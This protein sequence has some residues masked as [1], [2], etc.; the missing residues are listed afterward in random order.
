M[1][2]QGV[3]FDTNQGGRLP[4]EKYLAATLIE[5]DALSATGCQTI[6]AAASKHGLN[7]KYFGILWAALT[8]TEPSL[9]LDELRV[10]WR[11]A[12]PEDAAALAADI[13]AWQKSLWNFSS[14]G[15]IGREGGPKRWMEPVNPLTTKQDFSFKIPE[16]PDGADVT[17]SLVA[18]DAGDGN[19]GDFVIWQAPRLVAPG[20][21][22]LLLRDVRRIVCELNT[23]QDQLFATTAAYLNAADE[24]AS[25][26]KVDVAAWP[27]STAWKK[28]TCE[29]GSTTWGL[30]PGCSHRGGILSNKLTGV[31]GFEF[32]NGWGSNDTPLLVANSSDEH[33]RIPGNVKPHSVVVHPSPT[34]RAAVGWRSPIARN[35]RIEG[36]V[37]PAHPECGNGVTWSLD[38]APRHHAAA[39]GRAA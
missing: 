3:V 21:P 11:K 39:T 9:L 23:R 19:E 34:L 16:S 20:R 17:I 27:G 38:R 25:D 6:D 4:V 13:A 7:A 26:E 36:A 18:T 15:L 2:L 29:H 5:R 22:D 33:V 32:V 37:A 1:N 12:K 14:V 35:V 8:G 31:G 10:Q 28:R 24:I 30:V